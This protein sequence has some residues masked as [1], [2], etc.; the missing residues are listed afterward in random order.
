MR[1]YT[2]KAKSLTEGLRCS[3]LTFEQAHKDV[4]FQKYNKMKTELDEHLKEKS[5]T[6][7]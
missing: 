5:Q 2:Q 1:K 3:L 7:I 6:M 4:Q